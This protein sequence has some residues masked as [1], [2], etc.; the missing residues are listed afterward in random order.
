[1]AAL[2]HLAIDCGFG[3]SFNVMLRDRLI[4]R[5]ND[6]RIQR[7]LLSEAEL[8]FDKALKTALAMEMVDR[9]SEEQGTGWCLRMYTRR[10][11]RVYIGLPLVG[12]PAGTA[13]KT[14]IGAVV[15]TRPPHV[16]TKT[17]PATIVGKRGTFAEYAGR[18]R[19][20]RKF[21]KMGRVTCTTCFHCEARST[22][23]SVSR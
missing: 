9:D 12:K 18:D 5:I 23:P 7:R 15:T 3:D 22:T 19:I 2:R 6:P 10:R 11:L 13:I 1:M 16:G 20:Y 14:V 17:P 21:R 8:D 4:C